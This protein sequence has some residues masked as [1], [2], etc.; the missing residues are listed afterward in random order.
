MSEDTEIDEQLILI[1]THIRLAP[2][3]GKLSANLKAPMYVEE[4][5]CLRQPFAKVLVLST[6]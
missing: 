3:G 4:G 6:E 1:Q 5:M 2:M